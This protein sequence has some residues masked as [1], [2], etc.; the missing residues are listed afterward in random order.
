MVAS[1]PPVL[2]ALAASSRSNVA[3]PALN[4]GLSAASL[5]NLPP[6][7]LGPAALS[8]PALA[9]SLSPA[10][11]GG[12]SHDAVILAPPALMPAD[13]VSKE[14]PVLAVSKLEESRVIRKVIAN[15]LSIMEEERNRLI[16]IASREHWVALSF[17]VIA[18]AVFFTSVTL[19]I[20]AALPQAAAAFL[21]NLVPIFLGRTF[22]RREE[23]I[24]KQ[25]KD[26]S[27]DLRMSERARERLGIIEEALK[28]IPEEYW[29]KVLAVTS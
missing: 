20:L 25:I 16:P 7:N 29:D 1:T 8:A 11:L 14:I 23:A 18:G 2:F 22:F 27:A 4:V 9:P 24:E 21:A 5:P 28:V 15:Q 26:I 10:A 6:I 19:V 12:P 13:I 3:V 17:V